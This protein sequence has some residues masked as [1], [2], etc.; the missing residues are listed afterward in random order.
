MCCRCYSAAAYRACTYSYTYYNYNQSNPF[1]FDFSSFFSWLYLISRVIVYAAI[2]INSKRR[3]IHCA[4]VYRNYCSGLSQKGWPHDRFQTI[5]SI[6]CLSII[7]TKSALIAVRWLQCARKNFH[8]HQSVSKSSSI[9]RSRNNNKAIGLIILYSS[10]M[11]NVFNVNSKLML[12]DFWSKWG[13]NN[14]NKSER[15]KKTKVNCE[16]NGKEAQNRCSVRVSI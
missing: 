12:S 11:A 8:Q 4:Y 6:V 5:R 7:M 13:E 3:A 15:E 2:S 14:S 9:S 10:G 16:T 1:G